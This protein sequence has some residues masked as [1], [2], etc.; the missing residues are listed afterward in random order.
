M[1]SGAKAFFKRSQLDRYLAPVLT[2]VALGVLITT[3]VAYF[4]TKKTVEELVQ[5]QIIQTL[6]FLDREI[7]LQARDMT[8][9]TNMVAQE[10]VLRLALEDSYLGRSARAAAQRKLEIYVRSGAFER[11][12]LMNPKGVLVLSSDPSLA[13]TLDVSDRRYFTQAIAGHPTLETVPVSRV[14]GRP[15]M[16][17]STPLRSPDGA[18]LGVVVGIVHTDAFARDMLNDSR[19][20]KSGGAYIM[21][22][23]GM[24]LGAPAWGVPGIFGVG[25]DKGQ[26]ESLQTLLA[27]A[28]TGEIHHFER[29]GRRRMCITRS[30]TATGWMLVLEADEEN[31]LAPAT[32]LAAVSGII[33]LITLVVVMLALGVLRKV[34]ASLRK[35]EADHRTL[36][37]L[38]PV[39]ILTFGPS[40]RPEYMNRQARSILSIEPDAPLPPAIALEDSEGRLLT[41]DGSPFSRALRERTSITSL[42]TRYTRPGGERRALYLNAT[43]LAE[44]GREAHGVV[45][46]LEDITERMQALELLHQSEERFSSLFRLSPDSIVLSELDSGVIVDVNDAFSDFHGLARDEIIGKTVA[47]LGLYQDERQMQDIVE[48]VKAEGQALNVEVCGRN[49][50]GAEVVLSLSSQLMDIG[51]KR[52]RMTVARDVTANVEAQKAL[53]A[54]EEKF[55][56][57]VES[58]PMGMHFYVVDE[59]DRLILSGANPAS[60]KFLGVR[61]QERFG[62]PIEEAFSDLKDS[63]LPEMYRQ[64]ALG[65]LG[66]QHFEESYDD[67]HIRG[68]FEVLVFRSGERAV[69]ATYLDITERKEQ[70]ERLRQSEERFS[71]L[72]RF[73]PEAMALV[74]LEHNILTDVNEAFLQVTGYSAGELLGKKSR[75]IPFYADEASRNAIIQMLGNDG[76]VENYEFEG[77]RKDGQ[78]VKCALSCHIITLGGTRYILALLRD[79]TEIKKMQEMM[80]QTEKMISVGGIAAGIAHE[81]N[82]PLGIVLQAAQNLVQRT[83]ADFK[84]NIEVAANIG[85]NME[86]L[87]QY[88]Q[89]RKLDVFIEDI[90]AA[91]LRASAI[92]RHM[93]DFSRSSE[94]R[95]KI[96]DL[97]GIIDKAVTLAG[98]DYDLKKSYDFKRIK[99]VRDYADDLPG[100]S[101]TET[102]IEQVLLNLLRNSAQALAGASPPVQE[103]RIDIRARDSG[104]FVRI[105][106]EDN[107]PGMPPEVQRRVF[108]PFYTTKPP[109]VGT[110][111]GLSVSYFIIT[112]GHGGKMT[113]SSQ[114]GVG[115]LF[116]IELPSEPAEE[117]TA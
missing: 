33:S 70:E 97:P 83:R 115:T 71:R 3:L 95:R 98:S 100:V 108:E 57:I 93:L 22:R 111:L 69:T 38:S 66:R 92:I 112:K 17:T 36:T 88:M 6:N 94:S 75:E 32:R 54:S 106:I 89:A 96:C 87:K 53:S 85:L 109:G 116:R 37:E 55:R 20:G 24:V 16:V 110:G 12:Y 52:Y 84:K 74:E 31:V 58:S 105:E 56:S 49:S 78:A 29:D 48:R 28:E 86:L 23:E 67:G 1:S 99:I 101:C 47:E 62:L 103:P 44:E 80:I 63:A 18:I 72:F 45:A 82:N 90:Q 26:L 79:V 104:E 15:I 65:E 7:N 59:Q 61:H 81:I 73:S 117:G 11:V 46:T 77:R 76:H 21:T 4:Y 51:E 35:S 40:G 64:V 5:G 107:G 30:N 102:E 2:T 42:L 91:A 9:Q 50:S 41:G 68:V 60:D 27:N 114:P 13:G 10:E 39:G 19:I 113:V 14:T 25:T 34:M 8:M 43:P